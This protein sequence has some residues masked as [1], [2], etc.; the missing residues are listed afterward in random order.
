MSFRSVPLVCDSWAQVSA[1]EA[2]AI[3]ICPTSSARIV[4][5]EVM[6]L[7]MSVGIPMAA[8][9]K[10]VVPAGV[11]VWASGVGCDAWMLSTP[12]GV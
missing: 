9:E 12:F 7:P 3:L 5:G 1:G 4:C 2:T 10:L 11:P 8:W 6:G